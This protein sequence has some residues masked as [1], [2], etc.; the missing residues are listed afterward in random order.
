MYMC[1]PVAAVDI[2]SHSVNVNTASKE[3][4]SS[5]SNPLTKRLILKLHYKLGVD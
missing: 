2:T 3:I 5:A 1:T 4:I